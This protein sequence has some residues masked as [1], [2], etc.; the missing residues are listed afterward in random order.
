MQQIWTSLTCGL[1]QTAEARTIMRWA[2]IRVDYCREYT[3]EDGEH[4]HSDGGDVLTSL[5]SSIHYR[6]MNK[7]GAEHLLLNALQ[8]L[9]MGA[10]DLVIANV[11]AHF[12]D[13]T[14]YRKQ[15]KLFASM[16]GSAADHSS[17]FYFLETT[18]QHTPSFPNGYY[19]KEIFHNLSD[20]LFRHADRGCKPLHLSEKEED[21]LLDDEERSHIP[22]RNDPQHEVRDWRNDVLHEVLARTRW[23]IVPLA[24]ELQSQHDAHL[25][26]AN[27]WN[28]LHVM[29][30]ISEVKLDCLHW[31]MDSGVLR[32]ILTAIYNQLLQHESAALD[33]QM[34]LQLRDIP[35]RTGVLEPTR[36]GRETFAYLGGAKH[37]L[38]NGL[39]T[40]NRLGLSFDKCVSLTPLE[41]DLIPWGLDLD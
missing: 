29:A 17:S 32:Y 31:S 41:F 21:E 39:A 25:G 2:P 16:F 19:H 38:K 27:S 30:G 11:G 33:P 8:E 6:T 10:R 35:D 24:K 20:P 26:Y 7:Q 5:N 9:R 18:P 4:C 14:G 1:L 34:Y 13:P 37:R 36:Y 40:F 28:A 3:R 15:L 12:N 23:K 22:W